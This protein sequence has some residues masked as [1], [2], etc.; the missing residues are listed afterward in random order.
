MKTDAH[1]LIISRSV[2]LR[3][4]NVSDKSCRENQNTNLSSITFFLK[5]CRL[6]DNVEKLC[7]LGKTTDDNMA[8]AR[9][10]LD[11]SG[12]KHT[13]IICNT[14]CFCTATMFARTRLIVTLYVNSLSGYSVYIIN[15]CDRGPYDTTERAAG[16]RPTLYS[17][18]S[19]FFC[20]WRG[21]FPARYELNL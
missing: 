3:M 21:M 13:L 20:S 10:M 12:Y 15:R 18:F 4:K 17:I 19:F 2:L 14:Y 9:C 11:T 8:H 7:R 6:W 1:F 16:W 5:S